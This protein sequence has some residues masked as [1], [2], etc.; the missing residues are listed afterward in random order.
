MKILKVA[1][2]LIIGSFTGI[3][4][5]FFLGALALRPDPAFIANGGHAAPGDGIL[6]ML[7]TLAG[8]VISVP[9]SALMAWY[10]VFRKPKNQIPC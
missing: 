10:I 5:G 7:F 8:F 1:A 4:I 9:L 3:L 6:V 2:I